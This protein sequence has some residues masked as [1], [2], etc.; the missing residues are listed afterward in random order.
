MSQWYLQKPDRTVYGPV[1][2]D[3]LK[4]WAADGRVL[5]DDLVTSNRK[6]WHKAAEL[7]PLQMD[8]S[9]HLD[10]GRDFGPIHMLAFCDLVAD[11]EIPPH[12]KMTHRRTG[13]VR[14]V[15]ET[16]F[17]AIAA[18]KR[19][20][21]QALLTRARHIPHPARALEEEREERRWKRLYEEL[22]GSVTVHLSDM[23]KHFEH[24]I[25]SLDEQVRRER[26]SAE[27][28]R[29]RQKDIDAQHR[30]ILRQFRDLNDR[31]IR[32]HNQVAT[33]SKALME[34]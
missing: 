23:E 11:G 4:K 12:A 18:A 19:E 34:G 13:E 2:L 3:L 33:P 9:V 30:E 10:D 5:P 6:T 21:E 26:K 16:L 8:W 27:E 20:L 28:A 14:S 25:R 24:R 32:L 1:G 31:F 29:Q 17:P 15:A 7:E 22:R